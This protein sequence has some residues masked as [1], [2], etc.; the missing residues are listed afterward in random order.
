MG[1]VLKE[2]ICRECVACGK[3]IKVTLYNDRTYRGGHFFGDIGLRIGRKKA[4]YWE[5]PKCFWKK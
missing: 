4:E 2:K 5:C 1:K 3:E